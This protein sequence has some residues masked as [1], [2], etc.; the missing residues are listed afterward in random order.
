MTAAS[1]ALP[2][3]P[4]QQMERPPPGT[5]PAARKQTARQ[6]V[7]PAQV[8]RTER[9][10]LA[11]LVVVLHVAGVLTLIRLGT[12]PPAPPEVRTI[13][14]ALIQAETPAP[15]QIQPPA[16][17]PPEKVTRPASTPPRREP[18]PVVKPPPK[19]VHKPSPTAI[20]TTAQPEPAPAPTPTVTEVPSQPA[21]ASAAPVTT[22]APAA[23]PV[24]VTSARFDADY[25]NNPPPSYPQLSR[26][27]R[28]EGKVVLRVV[29][30]ADG[31]P[32]HIEI[33]QGSGSERLDKAA[34]SAVER[35]RF[36]PARQGDRAIE[37]AV[38]V[39]IIFKLEGN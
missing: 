12:R 14:V 6:T 9:R 2:P 35:W 1:I 38:L 18:K 31:V 37:A 3:P 16:P 19:P 5:S 23:T 36:V 13:E 32:R 29:V 30:A 10:G 22:A 28:E 7:A 33:S 4:T 15:V 25:L 26:R 24:P 27:M 21:A 11:V 34:R 39:P 17:P 20:E 8:T